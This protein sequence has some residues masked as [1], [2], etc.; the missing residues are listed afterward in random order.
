MLLVFREETTAATLGGRTVPPATVAVG[1]EVAVATA[2]L[3]LVTASVTVMAVLASELCGT[4]VAPLAP[5]IAVHVTLQ[6]FHW[7]VGAPAPVAGPATAVSSCPTCGV[8]EI[9]GAPTVGGAIVK[10]S[11]QPP[12]IEPVSPWYWSTTT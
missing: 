8:P 9:E 2:P 3:L 4:Y 7:Y 10:S 12:L 1:F 11:F 5:G 6:W